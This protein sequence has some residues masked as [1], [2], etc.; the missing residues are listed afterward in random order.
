[1]ANEQTPS[2]PLDRACN[3]VGRFFYH[4]ARVEKRID[5]AII[6]LLELQE[7]VAPVVTG[8][9]D[10]AQKLGLVWASA[11]AQATTEEAKDFAEKTCKDVFKVNNDRRTIAH[12]AFALTGGG[13]VQ[14]ART[15]T[16]D[17]RA[18]V[19]APVWSEQTF[20]QRYGE[21]TRL[22]SELDKLIAVIKPREV[23]MGWLVSDPAQVFRQPTI[24]AAL[25]ATSE[26]ADVI[27]PPSED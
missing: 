12:S 26:V 2:D 1:M 21:M 7:S 4:F 24:S 13:A 18:R 27:L 5:Q 15:V 20:T 25:V 22:E 3:L 19:V 17:G 6:K 10:F 11:N 23:P 9:M 14:F 16:R 8:S